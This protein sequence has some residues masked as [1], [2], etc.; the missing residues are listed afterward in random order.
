MSKE[1]LKG[2]QEAQVDQ[3]YRNQARNI[4]THVHNA[5]K[6]YGASLRW[7]FELFQNALDAGP[8]ADKSCV[9]ISVCHFDSVLK[10]EHDGAPFSY[11]DLAA[12]LSGGSNKELESVATTGRFGTGYL[13]THVLSERVHLSG[14]LQVENGLEKFELN[15]DRGGDENAILRNM[16]LCGA[17]IAEAISIPEIKDVRSAIFEYYIDDTAPITTGITS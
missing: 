3:T 2:F 17:S 10:F 9:D 4:W 6:D 11:K 14:L 16:Q 12:L 8:R 13:V 5:R 1:A 7:P 15:L